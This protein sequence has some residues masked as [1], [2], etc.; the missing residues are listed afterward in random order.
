M[1]NSQFPEVFLFIL[2]SSKIFLFIFPG[3]LI[4][5]LLFNMLGTVFQNIRISE[6]YFVRWLDE[7]K[8]SLILIFVEPWNPGH[9]SPVPD[10]RVLRE[11]NLHRLQRWRSKRQDLRQGSVPRGHKR[12]VYWS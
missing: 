5:S 6:T 3:F 9:I 8:Q 11:G 1:Y 2:Q 10:Q 12:G 4:D 7:D